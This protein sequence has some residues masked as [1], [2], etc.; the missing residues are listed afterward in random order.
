MN[1]NKNAFY[2]NRIIKL[3]SPLTCQTFKVELNGEENELRELLGTI[4]EIN[5]KSIK[6]LRDSYNNYYTLSSAVKN[7]YINTDPYNY[8]TVVIK[9][10]NQPNNKKYMKYP[11]LNLIKKEKTTSS[12]SQSIFTQRNNLISKSLN[13][14][15]NET[16]DNS[17]NINYLYSGKYN[18]NIEKLLKF[19]DDLYKRNYIDYNVENKLKKLIKQN[20]NEVLSILYS[21]LNIKSNKN[22]DEL[23]NKIKPMIHSDSP[24]SDNL[25]ESKQNSLSSSPSNSEQSDNDCNKKK[26]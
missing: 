14:F 13:R 17:N 9:G 23:A 3:I 10:F 25:E 20:N 5:P 12:I 4:L 19:A 8:Y 24:P 26:L 6:G 15:G 2:V 11:S 21:Y 22:Y 18:K 16:E 7:P 1:N